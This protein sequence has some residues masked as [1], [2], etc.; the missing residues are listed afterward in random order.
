MRWDVHGTRTGGLWVN[1]SEAKQTNG[2]VTSSTDVSHE[3]SNDP[4]DFARLEA[5]VG[6][7]LVEKRRLRAEN[8]QLRIELAERNGTVRDLDQQVTQ[9]EQ[10]R[11]DALKRVDDLIAQVEGFATLATQATGAGA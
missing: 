1:T 2:A 7:L 8:E 10:R 11:T 9:Q 3:I 5:A 4:F 6:Q